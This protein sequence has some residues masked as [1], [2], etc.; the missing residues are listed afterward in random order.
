MKIVRIGFSTHKHFNVV[1]RLIQLVDGTR[2]SHVFVQFDI[3]STNQTVIYEASGLSV[4]FISYDNWSIKS[5]PVAYA[6][7]N[8]TDE[9]FTRA[10]KFIIENCSKSYGLMALIGLGVKRLFNLKTNPFKD[11]GNSFICSELVVKTLELPLNADEVHP[12]DVYNYLKL[13]DN[14]LEVNL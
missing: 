11:G 6:T 14:I 3:S 12:S 4:K 13:T 2:F 9:Q 1:S 5:M 7:F 8:L 10:L